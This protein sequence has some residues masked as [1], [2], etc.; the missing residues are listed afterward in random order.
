MYDQQLPDLEVFR[1]VD[2]PE[3][4]VE[5]LMP[6]VKALASRPN[7]RSVD[8]SRCDL[9]SAAL[10]AIA[11]A[12]APLSKLEEVDFQGNLI[13]EAGRKAVSAAL[14]SRFKEMEEYI[15]D[16]EEFDDADV[17]GLIS[18]LEGLTV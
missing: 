7:L 10:V 14:G 9:T 11:K 16:D 15:T 6:L 12:L 3:L 17:E 13:N 18:D 5:G 4:G 8:F 2:A 1:L